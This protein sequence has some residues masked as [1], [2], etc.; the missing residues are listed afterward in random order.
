MHQPSQEYLP[1]T[2]VRVMKSS[3]M[4]GRTIQGVTLLIDFLNQEVL[5]A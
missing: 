1:W 3:T 4:I 5:V 2:F